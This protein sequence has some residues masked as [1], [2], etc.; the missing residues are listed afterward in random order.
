MQNFPAIRKQLT[1]ANIKSMVEARIGKKAGTFITSVL[2]LIGQDKNLIKCD[3]NLV[4]K[5]ALKAAGL[6]LPISKTLGFAYVI[7]YKNQPQFQMG[8]KG[9]IQLAIRTGQYKHLNAGEIYEGETIDVDRIR[10]T[11]TIY[12]QKTSDTVVAYFAYLEL[13]NGFEKAVVW[14]REQVEA[15]ARRFS[16]SY[17]GKHD[18]PWETDFDAM[19]KKTMLLQLLPK[20]G[21][22][23]IE[24]G[25]ALEK[26]RGDYQDFEA[27]VRENANTEAI[28]ITPEDTQKD[29]QGDDMTDTEKAEIVAKEVAE[30]E[31]DFD[32]DP[33]F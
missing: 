25:Q 29:H 30:A 24:L 4:V 27:K 5:E 26:D 3:P 23:T 22:M 19:A 6:D 12:G 14:T 31:A 8:Y 18:S 7:P 20:Y 11:M 33:G 13:I 9:Y 28:D 15:H 32:D 2:D 10:G 1:G 17:G 16:K 21:P